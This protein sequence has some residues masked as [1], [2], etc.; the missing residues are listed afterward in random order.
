MGINWSPH[1]GSELLD[2]ER[3]E[4]DGLNS[5]PRTRFD[6]NRTRVPRS[7]KL[8]AARINSKRPES[9]RSVSKL[10][11]GARSDEHLLESDSLRVGLYGVG[12]NWQG[13]SEAARTGSTQLRNQ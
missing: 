1:L 6:L 10:L 12:S 13:G 2:A 8:E 11:E 4:T 9:E 5:F 3:I 7:S